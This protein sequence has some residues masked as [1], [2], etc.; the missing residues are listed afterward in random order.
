MNL[1]IDTLNLFPTYTRESWTAAHPGQTLPAFDA[2]QRPKSWEDPSAKDNPDDFVIYTVLATD[3]KY[4]PAALKSADGKPFLKRT[5]IPKA[6]AIAV[7]IPPSVLPAGTKL[8]NPFPMPLKPIPQ[9]LVLDWS[10]KFGEGGQCDV[11]L[12]DPADKKN[13][14]P[15]PFTGYHEALLEK[16]AK[17]LGVD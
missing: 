6:D 5:A 11:I 4:A 7:N 16:I 15:I 10:M 2:T 1:S 14:L 12:R 3:G 9:G 8:L 13:V 17:A